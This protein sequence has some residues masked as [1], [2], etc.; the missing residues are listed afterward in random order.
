MFHMKHFVS[1]FKFVSHETFILILIPLSVP[2]ETI[3]HPQFTILSKL[4]G[5][6]V[7]HLIDD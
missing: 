5:F 2:R 7:K 3:K 6:H 4:G 1:Y